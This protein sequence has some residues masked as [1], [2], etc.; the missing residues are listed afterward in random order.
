MIIPPKKR[1]GFLT[2]IAK[3]FKL[4]VMTSLAERVDHLNLKCRTYL[5]PSSSAHRALALTVLCIA[6]FFIVKIRSG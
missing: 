3:H 1:V 5:A 4:T 2:H 6:C